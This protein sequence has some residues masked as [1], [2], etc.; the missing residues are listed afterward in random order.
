MVSKPNVVSGVSGRK[1]RYQLFKATIW[2]PPPLMHT[3]LWPIQFL[4]DDFA[5]DMHHNFGS[6]LHI[7]AIYLR[8]KSY[9]GVRISY[10]IVVK[11]C[12]Q[13]CVLS[14]I[15]AHNLPFWLLAV[16]WHAYGLTQA[17]TCW[18]L[19]AQWGQCCGNL[20]WQNSTRFIWTKASQQ[21][22]LHVISHKDSERLD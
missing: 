14:T 8:L 10:D 16:Y 21:Y 22:L 20:S 19:V 6:T 9:L 2:H 1:D 15:T 4:I 5:F 13:V 3:Y 17:P 7:G 11:H 18:Q 12:C